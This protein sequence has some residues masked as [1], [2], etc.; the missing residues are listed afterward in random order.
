MLHADGSCSWRAMAEL[1]TFGLS[2]KAYRMGT[3]ALSTPMLRV[4]LWVSLRSVLAEGVQDPFRLMEGL[5]LI[6]PHM[7]QLRAK[8]GH[9]RGTRA[10]LHAYG[11]N[12]PTRARHKTA[13]QLN[14]W[15]GVCAMCTD[16]VCDSQE[17][18]FE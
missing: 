18:F 9:K 2:P 8:G 6:Q 10:R 3:L 11:G 5:T 13:E 7:G 15:L 17:H 1:S 14:A 4:Q 16:R 12:L